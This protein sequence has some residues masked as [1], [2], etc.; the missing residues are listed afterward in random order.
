VID[1]G[2]WSAVQ[3]NDMMMSAYLASMMRAVVSLHALIENKEARMWPEKKEIKAEAPTDEK[4]GDGEAAKDADEAG[5]GGKD[6]N[7]SA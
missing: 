2:A 3:S 4:K 7:D 5:K 6:T 1:R